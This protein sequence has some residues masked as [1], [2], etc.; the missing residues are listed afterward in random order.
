MWK[1]ATGVSVEYGPL[2]EKDVDLI[3]TRMVQHG[4]KWSFILRSISD[5]FGGEAAISIPDD[6]RKAF[7]NARDALDDAEAEMLEM[8]F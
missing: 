6:R 7:E 4:A 5:T 8:G 1:G 3:L 2:T